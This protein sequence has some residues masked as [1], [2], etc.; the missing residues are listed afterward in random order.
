[1]GAR[2]GKSNQF[3]TFADDKETQ[4]AKAFIESV[5]GIFAEWPGV[6]QLFCVASED[7][8]GVRHDGT[9]SRQNQEMAPVDA[10]GLLVVWL[11]A[12]HS[13]VLI[14][15]HQTGNDAPMYVVARASVD[16]EYESHPKPGLDPADRFQVCPKPNVC[17]NTVF[18]PI[19]VIQPRLP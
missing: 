2:R 15:K 11:V 5:G 14:L 19:V 10:F 13:T 8:C 16:R 1:M 12:L 4:V 7:V 9:G 6:Y 3:V 18:T 17:Q